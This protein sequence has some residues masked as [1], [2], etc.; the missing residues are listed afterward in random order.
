MPRLAR[1]DCRLRMT[2][3][4]TPAPR[5]GRRRV[6]RLPVAG[7]PDRRRGL[8]SVD[9]PRRRPGRTGPRAPSRTPGYPR[10]PPRG[11][12]RAVLPLRPARRRTQVGLS[13]TT[14]VPPPGPLHP[15]DP[16]RPPLRAHPQR[17]LQ[18]TRP[19]QEAR[20]LRLQIPDEPTRPPHQTHPQRPPWPARPSQE[21]PVLR[22]QVSGDPTLEAASVRVPARVV[23]QMA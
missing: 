15:L 16:T 11:V 13:H 9:R 14:T 8:R 22:R 2:P 21:A 10:V 4:P 12:P 19:P 5:H 3:G 7:F 23:W 20:A 17:P 1:L 18:P 6:C